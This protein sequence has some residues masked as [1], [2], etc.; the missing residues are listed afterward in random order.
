[1]DVMTM[2]PNKIVQDEAIE[3]FVAQNLRD[4]SGISRHLPRMTAEAETPT[5]RRNCNASLV[6]AR[7][8]H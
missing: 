3:P 1:V 4:G 7:A 5:M 8:N 6:N 2:S